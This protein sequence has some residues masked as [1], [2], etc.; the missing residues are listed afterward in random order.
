M[1]VRHRGS[2]INRIMKTG[3]VAVA[4]AA[5]ALLTTPATAQQGARSDRANSGVQFDNRSDTVLRG[6][7]FERARGN[8]NN[9]RSDNRRRNQGNHNVSHKKVHLNAYGQTRQ[10]VK[11]LADKAIYACACQLELDAYKYGF[12]DAAFRSTPYY[13]QIGPN[14]FIVKGTAKLY[15]GYDYSR[16]SYDCVVRRGDIRKASNLHPVAYRG[17]RHNNRRNGF[18]VTGISFS[19]GNAW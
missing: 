7:N 2:M 17:K 10:E 1:C 12:K 14:Q 15:D 4:L 8:R 9:V 5:S 13:E 18:G 3:V 6:G 11:Y 19:F 16:Q